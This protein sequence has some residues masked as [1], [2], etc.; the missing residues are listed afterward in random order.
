MIEKC[1]VD[2]NV[3]VYL[4]ADDDPV[5][6]MQ[7]GQLLSRVRHKVVSWQIVNEVCANLIRKKGKSETLVRHAIDYMCQSCEVVNFSLP[8]LEAASDLRLKHGVSFWDSLVIAAALE[9]GCDTF[10]SEDMQ[11]GQKF[12]RMT[13][14]NI[15]K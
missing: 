7:A 12:G 10:A 9:A 6:K 15:F 4:L 14:R 13:V 8:L 5:K 1:F 3:W 11:D 2:S